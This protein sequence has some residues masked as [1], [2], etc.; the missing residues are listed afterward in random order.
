SFV[1]KVEGRVFGVLPV[2]PSRFDITRLVPM[3]EE[4]HERLAGVTVENLP[5]GDFI[6]RYDRKN[7]LF[8]LDPPYFGSEK[9]YG[10]ELFARQEFTKL[11]DQLATLKGQFILSLNDT[12]EVR[13]IFSAFEQEKVQTRYSVSRRS[14]KK[15]GELIIFSC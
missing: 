14:S 9:Y 12:P 2:R 7:T 8:Y 6:R 15:T 1:G 10:K 11:A 5:Y 3:L 13:D 4:L